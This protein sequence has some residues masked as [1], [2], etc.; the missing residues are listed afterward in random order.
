MHPG[1]GLTEAFPQV[2]LK[3][4]VLERV[5]F[6]VAGHRVWVRTP[7]HLALLSHCPLL[8]VM[9]DREVRRVK[10]GQVVTQLL[11]THPEED[12]TKFSAVSRRCAGGPLCRWHEGSW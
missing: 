7:A 3:P 8:R 6:Q 4:E 1:D 12:T 9:R 10:A 5:A 2:R 11:G